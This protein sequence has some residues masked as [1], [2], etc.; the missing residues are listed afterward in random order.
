MSEGLLL[1]AH[2]ARDPR[3]AEPFQLILTRV[4]EATQAPVELAFLELTDPG[5][6]AAIEALVQGG[7]D[8]IKV[9]PL[10][11]GQGGHLRRD[12]PELIAKASALHPLL[13]ISAVDAAGEAPGVLDALVRY[14]LD[15]I[16]PG[17]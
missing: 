14:C 11:L 4:K 13:S 2:G 16:G 7:C 5:F 15:S 8:R 9:V 12:L 6:G 17:V 3:W 10:F 1:F